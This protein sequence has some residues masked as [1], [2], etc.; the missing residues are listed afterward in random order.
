MIGMATPGAAAA[1]KVVRKAPVAAAPILDRCT[2]VEPLPGTPAMPVGYFFG[3]TDPTDSGD[4]CTWELVQENHAR[5]GRR[6]GHYLGISSK[7]EIS[8]TY[9][10]NVAFAFS[11]FG[12]YTR[13]SD[14]RV[15]RDSLADAG[16]GVAI[17]RMNQLEF[18][19]LSGEL[20]VRVL[21]RAPNQP[22]AMT[23]A[24][25]PRWSR[26]DSVNNTGQRAVG[27]GVEFKWLLDVVLTERVFAA[28]NL[29]YSL[30]TQRYALPDAIWSRSSAGD[31]SAALIG[32]VYAAEKQFLE[33]IYVGAEG[34]YRTSFDG[35]AFNRH[36]GGA[37]F[38]GPTLGIGFSGERFLSLVWLPQVTGRARPASA[39]GALEL[40]NYERHEIRLKLATPVTP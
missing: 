27:Y 17:N 25:E 38:F 5:M 29:N 33:S 28:V 9:G 10:H 19:G 1:D 26:F 4:P 30:G 6:D 16:T 24:V 3:M 20:F 2:K 32:Q 39:P 11:A 13:W 23:V 15:M 22:F 34:R 18:D 7:T 31:V 36:V 35:L 12:A 14:V 37:V 21:S 40:D 8:Y